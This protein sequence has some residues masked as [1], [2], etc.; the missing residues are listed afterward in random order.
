MNR[1]KLKKNKFVLE[2]DLIDNYIK[3]YDKISIDI[4]KK[5]NL[6]YYTDSINSASGYIKSEFLNWKYYELFE[7][8]IDNKS[9]TD[10]EKKLQIEV[11]R[12]GFASLF[13][14]LH[15][16][17]WI[18]FDDYISF[19]KQN[20]IDWSAY[21]RKKNSNPDLKEI[22]DNNDIFTANKTKIL[23]KYGIFSTSNQYPKGDIEVEDFF[24]P[25]LLNSSHYI[26]YD[27]HLLV[28]KDDFPFGVNIF[29]GNIDNEYFLAIFR[30]LLFFYEWIENNRNKSKNNKIPKIR[31][32]TLG[33]KVYNKKEGITTNVSEKQWKEAKALFF[34]KVF[35]LINDNESLHFCEK[36][37]NNTEF[38]VLKNKWKLKNTNIPQKNIYHEQSI[39]TD[40]GCLWLGPRKL[41]FNFL[42]NDFANMSIIDSIKKPYKLEGDYISRINI[43]SDKFEQDKQNFLD[44]FE[45]LEVLFSK[46]FLI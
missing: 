23:E 2:Q 20:K 21:F 42:P 30:R 45:S 38:Y 31:I 14:S 27:P 15:E 34:S 26:I 44:R 37:I 6:Q 46:S 1:Q 32:G 22:A 18:Q 12:T 8:I 28:Y 4:S 36:L 19:V 24:S 17:K 33:G 16:N 35:Q 9:L 7:K 40:Y 3:N 41:S 10:D 39:V 25:L 43:F 29:S 13:L 11:S 5:K